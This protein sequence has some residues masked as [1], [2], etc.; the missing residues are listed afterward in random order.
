MASGSIT[1]KT[2]RLVVTALMMSLIVIGTIVLRI[3]IPMTQGYV[4]LGDTMIYLGVMILGKK[5]GAAAAGIGSAM[6][7]VIGGFAMWAPWTLAIKYSM[8][9][10]TGLIIEK[11]GQNSKMVVPAMTAGGLIMCAGYLVAE[12]VMYGSWALAIPAVPWNIGQF[13]VGIILSLMINSSLKHFS[14]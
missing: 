2:E 1:N 6:G 12:R 4:H 14:K 10:V 3:P 11:S 5:Y 8:A 9:F 7:D 13:V